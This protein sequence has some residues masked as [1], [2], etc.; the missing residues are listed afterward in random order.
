MGYNLNDFK[1]QEN[2]ARKLIIFD[3]SHDVSHVTK[4]KENIICT[5]LISYFL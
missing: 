2:K 5:T 3:G 1:K 4:N